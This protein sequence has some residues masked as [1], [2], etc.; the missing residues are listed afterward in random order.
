M[1]ERAPIAHYGILDATSTNIRPFVRDR[2]QHLEEVK[3]DLKS[4]E[5]QVDLYDT[6]RNF[7]LDALARSGP[8]LNSEL[9]KLAKVGVLG[10]LGLSSAFLVASTGL[11]G[12]GIV[13]AMGIGKTVA[14]QL[15]TPT[16]LLSSF[17]QVGWGS[18]SGLKS[19]S[20]R[21]DK[22]RKIESKVTEEDSG[23]TR[24]SSSRVREQV[25]RNQQQFPTPIRLLV[26][27][28]TVLGL[29]RWRLGLSKS[30]RLA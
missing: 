7:A 15:T 25:L 19:F 6:K 1:I 4:F 21:P 8:T 22:S 14:S 27:T 10:A 26:Y 29:P 5:S 17:K 23:K 3:A 28:V 13:V 24:F 11:F 2:L 16:G 9:P 12:L 20:I 30:F 18:W